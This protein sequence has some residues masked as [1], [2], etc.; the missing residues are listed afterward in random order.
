MKLLQMWIQVKNLLNHCS[1]R[2][3]G[4]VWRLPRCSRTPVRASID[5]MMRRRGKKEELSH[6]EMQFDWSWKEPLWSKGTLHEV[7]QWRPWGSTHFCLFVA[8]FPLMNSDDY[9]SLVVDIML[10]V[11]SVLHSFTE[12]SVYQPRFCADSLKCLFVSS[13]FCE[14]DHDLLRCFIIQNMK[15]THLLCLFTCKFS[16]VSGVNPSDQTVA[17]NWRN[18]FLWTPAIDPH[19]SCILLCALFC[20]FSLLIF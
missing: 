3:W 6:R 16:P 4:G 5:S 8:F 12:F 19:N 9:G 17:N 14:T 18:I 15:H 2:N 13:S 1:W 10:L 7:E 11:N 20:K